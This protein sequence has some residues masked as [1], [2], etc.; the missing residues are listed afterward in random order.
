MSKQANRFKRDGAQVTS[1][2]KHK[3]EVDRQM[4]AGLLELQSKVL[5]TQP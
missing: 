5:N 1:A 4:R 2:Q 3:W